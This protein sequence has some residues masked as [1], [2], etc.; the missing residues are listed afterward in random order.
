MTD[1]QQRG[2]DPRLARKRAGWTIVDRHAFS[3]AGQ[4]TTWPGPA[5]FRP[6]PAGHGARPPRRNMEG[7]HANRPRP[8][9]R[10]AESYRRHHRRGE[11]HPRDDGFAAA[12]AWRTR[13][14]STVRHTDTKIVG[15]HLIGAAGGRGPSRTS[16]FRAGSAGRYAR[17]PR[18]L[19][20]SSPRAGA[21]GHAPAPSRLPQEGARRRVVFSRKSTAPA[22][23]ARTAV[24]HVAMP[25]HRDPTAGS[26]PSWL[27]RA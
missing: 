15:D 13:C 6:R 4:M 2:R 11:S 3:G 21:R 9:T 24:S 14:T 10:R 19:R 18:S 22:F 8:V 7:S 27:S 12:Q 1:L 26:S 20:A 23:I 16:P 5:A 17:S 25:G